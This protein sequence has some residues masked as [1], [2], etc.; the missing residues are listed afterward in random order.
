MKI[1]H[2]ATF[3]SFWLERD[4]S[5]SCPDMVRERQWIDAKFWVSK[6]LTKILASLY[7]Q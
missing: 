1:L 6:I 4:G 3:Y 2:K 5:E 7:D